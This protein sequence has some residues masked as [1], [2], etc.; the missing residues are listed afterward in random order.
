MKTAEASQGWLDTIGTWLN[1]G[2]SG[3]ALGLVIGVLLGIAGIKFTALT[4]DALKLSLRYGLLFLI[5]ASVATIVPLFADPTL[6]VNV[7]V[8]PD[9]GQADPRAA[10]LISSSLTKTP[11]NGIVEVSQRDANNS[12]FVDV[13]SLIDEIKNEKIKIASISTEL[14]RLQQSSSISARNYAIV[15]PKTKEA[16]AAVARVVT[17][18]D[19]TAANAA[20]AGACADTNDAACGWAHL[21][22]GDVKVAQKYFVSAVGDPSLSTSQRA[23]AHNGLGYTYL[24]QGKTHDAV[25]QIKQSSALGDRDAKLQ[26][27]A[28]TLP[29]RSSSSSDGSVH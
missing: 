3:L 20:T 29:A 17:A 10:P 7:V 9:I 21:A 6:K 11:I 15:A 4:V 12:V 19:S 8:R 23:S 28:L 14:D 13:G 26:W 27:D 18:A 22:R 5:V 24:T 16:Q 1:H 25:E 2:P